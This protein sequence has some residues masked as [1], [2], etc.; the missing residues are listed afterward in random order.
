MKF[1]DALAVVLKHE[2][3]YV[4]HPDDPG[5]ETNYGVTA[6]VARASGYTGPMREIPMDVVRAIYRE[7]YWEAARCDELPEPLRLPVFDAAVN[8]GVSRSIQW[9]QKALGV[10]AD[11]VLGP[12][13]MAA[14]QAADAAGA[15]RSMC[16]ERLEFL[17]QLNHFSTF[18]RGWLRRVLDILRRI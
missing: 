14:A 11:G 1:E 7:K 9:L 2:G 8:S 6:R 3:G 15:A 10:T 18:G 17:V 12:K 13:T 16:Y 5:G 4:N